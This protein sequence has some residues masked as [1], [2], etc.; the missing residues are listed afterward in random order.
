[1]GKSRTPNLRRKLYTRWYAMVDRCTRPEHPRYALYGGSGV[2]VCERWLDKENFISDAKSLPGYS[3]EGVLHGGLHLDKDT[4]IAG[5]M[6]YS[7]ETC[8][9]I[10]RVENNKT[11][12]NQQRSFIA[13]SPNGEEYRVVNQSEFAITHNLRQSTISDCLKGRVRV[14]RGWTFRF[15]E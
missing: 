6:E 12:P 2:T 4:R 1:M 5:S 15:E 13:T 9:F 10:G 14:H 3:E 11:K 7:P 8:S